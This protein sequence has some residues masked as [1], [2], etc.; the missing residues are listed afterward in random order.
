MSFID[1]DFLLDE[2]TPIQR[3][4]M[5]SA[6]DCDVARISFEFAKLL[7]QK[8]GSVLWIDGNLG[9]KLPEGMPAHPD[10]EKVLLGQLPL[11]QILQE[12][13][14]ISVLTGASEH[15]LAELNEIKQ[16]QFLQDLGRIYPNFDRVV[17]SVDGKN[18]ALQKKWMEQAESIY[19]LFNTKNLLLGRTLNWLQENP[20]KAKGLIG[21]GK[22]DQAVLLSYMRLKGILGEVPELILDIKKIAP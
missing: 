3:I 11:T 17:L 15:F 14:G 4:L 8:G 9:E 1:P 13:Q 5:T 22:N 16:Y 6:D 7:A 20:S 12:V 21:I 18:P 19:L 2:K 10:L